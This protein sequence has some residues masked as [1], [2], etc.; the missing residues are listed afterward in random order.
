MQVAAPWG[1][2]LLYFLFLASTPNSYDCAFRFNKYF[3]ETKKTM[4]RTTSAM[5]TILMYSPYS[6]IL[7]LRC[8][9]GTMEWR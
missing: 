5:I 7:S 2:P 1:R 6:M 9:S 3:L 8:S 4:A